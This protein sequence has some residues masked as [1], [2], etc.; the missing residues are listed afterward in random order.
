[1]KF[2]KKLVITQMIK[3]SPALMQGK[4]SLPYQKK[5]YA[6]GLYATTTFPLFERHA[7]KTQS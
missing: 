4:I 2:W 1:M 3:K 5:E 7:M 6:T